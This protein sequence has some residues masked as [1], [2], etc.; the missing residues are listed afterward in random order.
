MEVHTYEHMHVQKEM[1]GMVLGQGYRFARDV[2]DKH[3]M[4]ALLRI[5]RSVVFLTQVL[6]LVATAF[7]SVSGLVGGAPWADQRTDVSV[8]GK[9]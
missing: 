9:M 6:K 5:H 1:H 7:S 4:C 3:V 2:C 8:F